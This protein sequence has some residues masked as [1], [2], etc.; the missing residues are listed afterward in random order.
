MPARFGGASRCV[1][2]T[3][4]GGLAS[5]QVCG[6]D[7]G[8]DPSLF[9]AV[10]NGAARAA[11]D[12]EV[13]L[14]ANYFSALKPK[15]IIKV[16]ESETASQTELTRVFHKL[17]RKGGTEP[18]GRR[19]VEVPADVQRFELRDARAQFIANVPK[20]ALARGMSG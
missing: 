17:D 16:M 7:T 4:D 6:Q 5:A 19:I 2:L 1:E 12:A 18:L 10:P 15:P 3:I 20:G 8:F 13:P 14:A 9:F 11:S